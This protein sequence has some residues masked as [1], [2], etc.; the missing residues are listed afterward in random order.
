M[1]NKGKNAAKDN[2]SAA[3]YIE[4]EKSE[5]QKLID[6]SITELR[7]HL[8]V[9]RLRR[10]ELEP[11]SFDKDLAQAAAAVGNAINRLA[12]ETRQQEKHE[13]EMVRTMTPEQRDASILGYAKDVPRARRDQLRKVFD[14]L[15]ADEGGI[16]GL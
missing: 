13:R 5:T 15:D 7:G 2:Q 9:I 6:E 10:Q 1:K 11:G 12:A 3:K 8:D 16:L 14:Q 4:I